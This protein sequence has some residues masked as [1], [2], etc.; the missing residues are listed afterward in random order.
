VRPG[1]VIVAINNTPVKGPEQL[2]ELIAKA[3]KTVALLVQRDDARIFISAARLIVGGDPFW[4]GLRARLFFP[5]AVG[6]TRSRPLE[7]ARPGVETR[8]R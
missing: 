2:K 1:D 6:S 5:D 8:E 4:A 3:G 7:P